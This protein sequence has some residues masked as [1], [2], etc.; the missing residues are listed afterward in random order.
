MKANTKSILIVEDDKWFR[1]LYAKVLSEAN[2]E[3]MLA[4]NAY[5]AID[6]VAS[7]KI[8]DAIML[9]IFLPGVNGFALIHEL[10]SYEDTRKVPVM[11]CSSAADT[12][13]QNNISSYGVKRVL[14]KTSMDPNDLKF[15]IKGLFD[16]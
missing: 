2:Y 15:I 4:S 1:E 6:T 10:Q 13:D 5:E 7:G 3:V 16:E 11:I 8:P 12:V 14:D 9:D